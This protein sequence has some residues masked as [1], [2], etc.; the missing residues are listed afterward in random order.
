VAVRAGDRCALRSDRPEDR[1]RIRRVIAFAESNLPLDEIANSPSNLMGLGPAYGAH[2]CLGFV[3]RKMRR[4][5][6][7]GPR[8]VASAL[9][10]PVVR[11]RNMAVAALE[12]HPIEE[13]G[14]ELA[15]D[16]LRAASDEPDEQVRERMD[17]VAARS[18]SV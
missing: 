12:N 8:L 1:D 13:W 6:I 16:V 4:E 11:N 18:R 10:S 17:A 9:R 14:P 3:V 2:R 7:F 15:G 5:F